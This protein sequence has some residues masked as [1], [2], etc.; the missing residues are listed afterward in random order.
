MWKIVNLTEYS[1]VDNEAMEMYK[2]GECPETN[3]VS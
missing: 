3:I 2:V 1:F